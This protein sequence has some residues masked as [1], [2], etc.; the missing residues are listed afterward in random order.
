MIKLL[1]QGIIRDKSRSV[2]PFIVVTIG[3]ALMIELVG[4]MDGMTNGMLNLTANLDTGRL[5]LVNKPFYDEEHLNPMDRSLAGQAETKRWLRQNG[6][7]E[8]QWA[9]RIRWGAILDAPDEKG[10]TKSQT[11]VLGLAVDLFSK[12][13]LERERLRLKEAL[14]EG[15]LPK[16]P[17]EML[18]GY[19]L[20]QTLGLQLG[21]PVT[22]I[23]QT[24][25]GGLAAD[26]YT[27]AGFIK[28]GVF[29]MDKKMVLIDL[30][31]AQDTFYMEDMVTDWLGFLPAH[32]PLRRYEEIRAS[33]NIALEEWIKNP[34][35]SWAE[36]DRPILLTIFDQRNMG[37][38]TDKIYYISAIVIGVFTVLMVLVLWNA[39]I[40]NGIHRYGE[41][42]LRLALGETP[43]RLIFILCLEGIIVGILGSIA[44][45]L[46][47]GAVV[48]YLQEVGINMGDNFAKSGIMVHDVVRAQLSLRGF[49]YGIVPG[50]AASALGTLFAGLAI[51]QRSEAALFRE[52]EAG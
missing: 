6:D 42:G 30:A 3:V 40:L 25:D 52:L 24:F 41:I 26:N 15:S 1:F 13:S 51:F 35:A 45:S 31:D 7:P 29:A 12:D 34:P 38:L 37:V 8:I 50:I 39:G 28:F 48:Y 11:P 49:V 5:R 43:G 36:D 18:V 14:L 22:L 47:G 9:P 33:M 17:K 32:V 4:F 46:L 21:N 16:N 19:Q 27:V 10:E 2:F 20:A 44:G 23:G